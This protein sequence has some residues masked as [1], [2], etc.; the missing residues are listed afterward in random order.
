MAPRAIV[1]LVAAGLALPAA[2]AAETGSPRHADLSVCRETGVTWPAGDEIDVRDFTNR[3]QGTWELHYRTIQGVTI[4]TDSYFYFDLQARDAQA[5]QGTALMLDRGNLGNMDP[6]AKCKACLA[7]AAVG[8]L[9]KVKIARE[10]DR[11]RVTLVMDGDYLGSYGEF[12]KGMRHTETTTFARYGDVYLAGKL[13]SPSGVEGGPDDVWD[14]ISLTDDVLTYVSCRGGF[15]DRFV[16]RS[17]ARPRVDGLDLEQ[18]WA[19]RKA[20]GSLLRPVPVAR[21]AGRRRP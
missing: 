4:D 5:A 20:D 16:K 6:L 3:L 1:W 8:A 15:I 17:S 14:R 13:T 21:S 10:K 18:T 9:W 12:V 11:P 19:R 2:G 7:D